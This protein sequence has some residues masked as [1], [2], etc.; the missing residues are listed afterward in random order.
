M[1]KTRALT[2]AP[3]S[4]PI[5]HFKALGDEAGGTGEAAPGTYEALVA[6]FGNIDSHGDRMVKGFFADTLKAP[7]A[8]RG[9]P[10][11]VWS[12]DWLTPPI[13]ASEEAREVDRAEAEELAGKKLPADVTGA[14]YKRDRL[15]IGEGDDH[16]IARQV[17]T[18]MKNVG[19]DGL[20]VLREFSFGYRTTDHDW[21]EIDV[22]LLDESLKWTEGDIRLLLKGLLFETGPTLVGSNPATELLAVKAIADVLGDAGA[23]RFLAASRGTPVLEERKSAPRL[24]FDEAVKARLLELDSLRPPDAL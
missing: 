10:P 4:F 18:G 2:D 3:K 8:G 14:L 19:G 6:M 22:D 13:G 20:P 12:H 11:I 9:L 23:R 24:P 17:W 15:F 21:E 16:P 5:V 1:S 7:P